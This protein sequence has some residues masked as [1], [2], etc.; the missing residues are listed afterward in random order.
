MKKI[1]GEIPSINE[2]IFYAQ[3]QNGILKEKN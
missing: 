3:K 2:E 1:E